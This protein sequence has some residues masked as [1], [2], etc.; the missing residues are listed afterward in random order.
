MQIFDYS[1]HIPNETMASKTGNVIV[2]PGCSG[3]SVLIWLL[4]SGEIIKLTSSV[5]SDII[6]SHDIRMPKN[7][8][9]NAKIRKL[10]AMNLVKETMSEAELNTLE[11]QLKEQEAS[12]KKKKEEEENNDDGSDQE[13]K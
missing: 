6:G 11:S 9:K 8:S 13:D 5:L 7:S 2:R 1:L 3:Q 4:R 12:R 10:M